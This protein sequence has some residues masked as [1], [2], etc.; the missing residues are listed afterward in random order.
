MDRRLKP[1]V[2]V[3]EEDADIRVLVR[4][5][6]EQAGLRVVAATTGTDA[7]AL[8]DEH[9]PDVL[10]L[11]VGLPGA[12]GYEVCRAVLASSPSP[13]AVVF[14]T[15]RGAT[16]DRIAGLDAGVVDYIAKPLEGAELVARVQAALRTKLRADELARRASTDPLTGLP[17]RASLVDRLVEHIALAKRGRT[18]SCVMVDIDHFKNL[19]STQGHA[20]GDELLREVARRLCGGVRSS[21]LVF[22]YGGDEFLVLLPDT[23]LAGAEVVAGNLLDVVGAPVAADEGVETGLSVSVGVAA[24]KEAMAGAEELLGAADAALYE[25]K[26]QGRARLAVSP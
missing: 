9:H 17:N 2:L 22:R 15:A 20:A 7:I 19:N 3:A 14:L 12:S 23:P 1:L 8:A 4:M 16:V 25:A 24:W 21:D 6:L 26:R 10:L 11:D 5:R 13:P 18:L